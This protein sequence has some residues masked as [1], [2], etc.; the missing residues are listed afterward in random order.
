MVFRHSASEDARSGVVLATPVDKH[1][2]GAR[3]DALVLASFRWYAGALALVAA[4]EF[5][6]LDAFSSGAFVPCCLALVA[7]FEF[8]CSRH[9]RIHAAGGH[10]WPVRDLPGGTPLPASFAAYRVAAI[11]GRGAS[12]AIE[13]RNGAGDPIGPRRRSKRASA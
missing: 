11:L 12:A 5:S 4:F 7:A 8:S 1:Q 2:V 9:L 13:V 3:H 10:R 6:C